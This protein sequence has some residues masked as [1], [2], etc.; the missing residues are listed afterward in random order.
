MIIGIEERNHKIPMA[1]QTSI[2]LKRKKEP[3][4]MKNYLDDIEYMKRRIEHLEKENK[5]LF[6]YINSLEQR[7]GYNFRER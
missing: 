1:H 6:L 3:G 7:F 4:I 2:S 5:E